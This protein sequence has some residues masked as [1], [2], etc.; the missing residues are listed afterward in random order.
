MTVY[1]RARVT[2][3]RSKKYIYIKN[4]HGSILQWPWSLQW[5][6]TH[7]KNRLMLFGMLV[8]WASWFCLRHLQNCVVIDSRDCIQSLLCSDW[9]ACFWMLFLLKAST[10]KLC[11]VVLNFSIHQFPLVITDLINHRT[12]RADA[13]SCLLWA[14]PGLFFEGTHSPCFAA[15]VL[16]TSFIRF[17]SFLFLCFQHG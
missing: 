8:S 6:W 16:L 11:T 3:I 4:H 10:L 5:R 1:R 12:A 15:H 13:L 17:F 14:F 2:C 9:S 7:C